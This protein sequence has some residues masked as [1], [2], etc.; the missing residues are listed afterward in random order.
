M[1]ALLWDTGQTGAAVELEVLWNE[2]GRQQPFS[3]LC[4]YP[5]RSVTGEDQLDAL[6]EVCAAHV[7]AAGLPAESAAAVSRR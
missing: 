3:L 1:V 4:A 7:A 5:A 2:L 6:T